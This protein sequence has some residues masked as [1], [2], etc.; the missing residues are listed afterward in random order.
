MVH[1]LLRKS[2]TQFFPSCRIVSI[3]RFSK[4][5]MNKTFDVTL[6]DG[7]H[8]IF[9]YYPGEKWKPAKEEY[10]YHIVQRKTSVPVP[11]F[12]GRGKQ[13]SILEKIEGKELDLRDE[14]GIREAGKF[15]AQLHSIHFPKYGWIVGR[16]ITPGFRSWYDF[17]VFDTKEKLKKLPKTPEYTKM[18]KTVMQILKDHKALLQ[19]HEK[20]CLLHKDYHSS[21]IITS[22]KIQGI[23]DFEWAIAGHS[24]FDLAKSLL[25]M[26]NGSLLEKIFLQGYGSVKK[27][28]KDFVHRKRLYMLLT[29]LSSLAISHDCKNR[30]W[31]IHN[32]KELMGMIKHEYNENG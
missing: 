24:E 25:W 13:F 19:I 8:V 12:L 4:G 32:K 22:G 28:S 26:F 20:P 2:I 23:I 11:K 30:R 1:T 10:V 31:C 21:H 5:I 6:S 7:R 27:I 18:G 17:L 14:K 29:S 15:L 16:T 3:Q 9:R